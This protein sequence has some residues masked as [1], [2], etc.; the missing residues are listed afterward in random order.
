MVYCFSKNKKLKCTITCQWAASLLSYTVI[1]DPIEYLSTGKQEWAWCW[2]HC[3][4]TITSTPRPLSPHGSIK[5]SSCC[6]IPVC[7]TTIL[8]IAWV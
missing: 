8:P 3:M 7:P 4:T 6:M 5:S 1:E 2:Q